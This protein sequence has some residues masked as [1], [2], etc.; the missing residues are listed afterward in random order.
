MN[1]SLLI[2]GAIGI[3]LIAGFLYLQSTSQT[4]APTTV[5]QADVMM[6]EKQLVVNL[7]EQNDSGEVGVATLTEKDGKVTVS[8]VVDGYQPNAQPAHIHTGACPSPGAVIYPLT[9]VVDGNSETVLDVTLADLES[10]LPLAVNVHKSATEANIY[11][12]CGDLSF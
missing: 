10:Q 4:Q 6:E 8:L 9:N 7:S 12:S 2:V 5:D 1:K 11:T 3:L